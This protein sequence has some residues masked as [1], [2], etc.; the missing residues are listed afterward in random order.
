MRIKFEVL[1]SGHN[2]FHSNKTN[3]DY[4]RVR[5]MGFVEDCFGE[6]SPATADMGFDVPLSELPKSGEVV[7]LTISELSTRSSLCELTF[8]KIEPF[9]A[10]SG[11]RELKR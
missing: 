3:R 10:P 6:K 9:V 8:T 11:A 5:L 1:G 4:Q 2:S 7:V